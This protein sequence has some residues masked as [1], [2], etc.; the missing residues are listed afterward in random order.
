MKI[1][2]ISSRDS[3]EKRLMHFKSDK[4]ITSDFDTEEL[5]IGIK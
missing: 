2:I 3:D 1:N 4:E 5:I